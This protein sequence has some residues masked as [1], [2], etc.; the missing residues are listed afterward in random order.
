MSFDTAYCVCSTEKTKSRAR[1]SA[2]FQHNMRLHNPANADCSERELNEVLIGDE[3][4]RNIFKMSM[5]DAKAASDAHKFKTFND[6]TR[7]TK[8]FVEKA[9]G[10]KVRK[11]AV[12]AIEVVLTY[13]S[14]ANDGL[15]LEQW[16]KENVE[17]LKSYF[18]EENIMSAVLHMD[19]AVPHIHA[20]VTPIDRESGQPK[21]NAKKWLGG[22]E[23]MIQ[24]QDD[25]AKAMSKFNLER[26]ERAT[27]AKHEDISEFCKALNKAAS[28]RPPERELFK[29]D[30]E[31]QAALDDYYKQQSIKLF[32]L[33]QRLKRLEAVDKTRE[34]NN[35]TYR[36]IAEARIAGYEKQIK[37]LESSLSDSAKKAEFFDNMR[38]GMQKMKP[39][40]AQD[41]REK[42]NSIAKEGGM[43][44]AAM[45]RRAQAVNEE[46]AISGNGNTT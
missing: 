41:F 35:R 20:M 31:Y 21:F 36:D 25:Y 45:A 44:A 15:D 10:R 30:A 14:V 43:L 32:A 18:G 27:R 24:M 34:H 1:L 13:S 16:K 40:E 9:T 6:A 7:E 2:K 37:T 17:W 5:T 38:L 28:K 23:K 33:E 12:L 39:E 46:Q 8:D 4:V 42:I 3:S 29:N 22:K 26:G 19:E 11:D